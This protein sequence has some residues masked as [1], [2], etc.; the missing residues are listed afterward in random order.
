[1]TNL[2]REVTK[3]FNPDSDVELIVSLEDLRE[4]QVENPKDDYSGKGRE[5]CGYYDSSRKW[6]VLFYPCLI[7]DRG[8]DFDRLFEIIMHELIHHRQ[9]TCTGSTCREVCEIGLSIDEVQKFKGS[10]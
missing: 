10:E 3:T 4:A 2:L 5:V 9:Y 6:I 1:L 7:G 8:L